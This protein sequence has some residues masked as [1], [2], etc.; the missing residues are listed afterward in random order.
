MGNILPTLVKVRVQI[1]SK[2]VPKGIDVK[3]LCRYMCIWSYEVNCSIIL[4]HNCVTSS[5]LKLCSVYKIID[6]FFFTAIFGDYGGWINHPSSCTAGCSL[7]IKERV[8]IFELFAPRQLR[9]HDSHMRPAAAE[10]AHCACLRPR[11]ARHAPYPD[12][13][14]LR[15][16]HSLI[17]CAFYR[18]DS[19]MTQ[20]CGFMRT[21]M[22]YY[23][24]RVSALCPLAEQAGQVLNTAGT[25][26]FLWYVSLVNSSGI[27]Q[28]DFICKGQQEHV[29][30]AK[31]KHPKVHEEVLFFKLSPAVLK[32]RTVA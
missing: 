10:A 4:S 1:L 26:K 19:R 15:P 21:G 9:P 29:K 28:P 31:V 13:G 32:M 25:Q 7:L 3:S 14:P 5:K 11:A 12:A 17:L 30:S 18:S 8:L 2:V 6:F 23:L 24:S 20:S 16:P 22:T 27:T